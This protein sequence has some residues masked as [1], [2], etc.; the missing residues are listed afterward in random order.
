MLCGKPAIAFDLDGSREVVNE[1]TGRLIEAESTQQLIEASAELI[2]NKELR[3]R[4]GSN[5]RESV[6]RKFA[7]DTMVD[8]IEKVYR[9]L[10]TEDDC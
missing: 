7:P 10:L 2:E 1:N 5:A 8:T 3:L 9:K 6:K 4:L